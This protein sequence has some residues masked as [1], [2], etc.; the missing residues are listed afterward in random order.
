MAGNRQDVN[1]IT[2]MA[3]KKLQD[4]RLPEGLKEAFTALPHVRTAYV[5][6]DE[7]HYHPRPGYGPVH[8][9]D[10]IGT[11]ENQTNKSNS[12]E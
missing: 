5:K 10:V 7:W 9:K 6:G 4:N 11:G 1:R 3:K 12:H 8:R 2:E